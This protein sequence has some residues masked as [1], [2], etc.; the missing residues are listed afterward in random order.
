MAYY[1][2]DEPELIDLPYW[3]KV[4]FFPVT[5]TGTGERH[6]YK[7]ADAAMAAAEQGNLYEAQQESLNRRG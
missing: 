1:R 7:T 5:Y 4:T 3:G 6:L 2:T